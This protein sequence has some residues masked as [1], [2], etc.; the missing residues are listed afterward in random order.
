MPTAIN[1]QR[2]LG[3]LFSTLGKRYGAAD[4]DVRPVLEQ[5]LYGICREGA[6]RE[7]ADRAF[8][9]LQER[10]FD[11]N[12]IRVSSIREVEEA[13]GDLPDAE[14]RAERVIRFLQQ[15][16]E[17]Y[18]SFDLEDLHKKGLK[19]AAKHL[20]GYE[21]ANDYVG[22]WVVQQSLGGHAIPLDAPT[23]RVVRRLG[24]LENEEDDQET[25]RASL[26]HLVPKARGPLFV[27]LVS[28][29]AE[30]CCAE[31]VP[32]CGACPLS[33]DCPTGQ[34]PAREAATVGA[35]SARP[36]PR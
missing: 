9:S 18:F 28:R 22:A 21:A 10:F 27:D 20:S 19:V 25:L 23:L 30:E 12:E 15:V 26:E 14:V 5:F 11:W 6:T 17:K 13:L 35:R 33:A 3:Q 31:D 24:L 2:L 36:K 29:L 1:K 4:E 7:R 32:N 16:F 34:D 8:R